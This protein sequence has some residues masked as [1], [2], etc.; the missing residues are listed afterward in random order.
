MTTIRNLCAVGALLLSLACAGVS[1][2]ENGLMPAMAQ[3]Y[4]TGISP[5]I[6]RGADAAG[7]DVSAESDAF[8]NALES[9]DRELVRPLDWTA[10]RSFALSGIQVRLDAGEIGPGVSRSLLETIAQ[11]DARHSQLLLR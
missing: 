2:R 11:F 7:V 1:A 4:T 5:L 8:L 6:G 9:G 3:A 10:L